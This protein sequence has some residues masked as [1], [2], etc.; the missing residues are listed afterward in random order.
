MSLVPSKTLLR[1]CSSLYV[2]VLSSVRAHGL[3]F[4][5]SHHSL[6]SSISRSS[7]S[8]LLSSCIHPAPPNTKMQQPAADEQIDLP[9]LFPSLFT[10]LL[11][12]RDF[13]Y[14]LGWLIGCVND[15]AYCFIRA[16][17]EADPTGDVTR[18]LAT[19][20]VFATQYLED[21]AFSRQPSSASQVNVDELVNVVQVIHASFGPTGLPLQPSWVAINNQI[22]QAELIGEIEASFVD[23]IYVAVIQHVYG[24]NYNHRDLYLANSGWYDGKYYNYM[25]LGSYPNFCYSSRDRRRHRHNSDASSPV[26]SRRHAHRVRTLRAQGRCLPVQHTMLRRSPSR[27]QMPDLL[28]HCP[29]DTRRGLGTCAL[30][31]ATC[32]S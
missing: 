16:Y 3:T 14:E 19:A 2:H 13:P 6:L 15:A 12:L 7:L 5:V 9:S 32:V 29:R 21:N 22:T 23:L 17:V 10:S 31:R 25:G 1:R 30:Q 18:H 11:L 26:H 27:H 4:A 20:R 24:G 8:C 28:L